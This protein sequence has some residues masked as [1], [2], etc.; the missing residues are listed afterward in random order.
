MFAAAGA[1]GTRPEPFRANHSDPGAEASQAPAD[2][3]A[4]GAAAGASAVRQTPSAFASIKAQLAQHRSREAAA[5]SA[6]GAGAADGAAA[7]GDASAAAASHA[8][9]PPA[10]PQAE[11]GRTAPE[12]LPMA[13]DA[14]DDV[15]TVMAQPPLAGRANEACYELC[16]FFTGAS[17]M[18]GSAVP[19][20]PPAPAP[21]TSVARSAAS[22]IAFPA[23]PGAAPAAGDAAAIAA[24]AGATALPD[25][26][27][28]GL[29]PAPGPLHPKGANAPA[30]PR[31]GQHFGCLLHARPILAAHCVTS[32]QLSPSGSHVLLAYGRR[33]I[34]LCSLVAATPGGALAAVHSV[35][36]VY[37]LPDLELRRVVLSTDD[38]V[39]VAV[40]NTFP[41]GGMAYGTKEGRLRLM[42][43]DR[44]RPQCSSISFAPSP[45]PLEPPCDGEDGADAMEP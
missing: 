32:V 23:A 25:S 39:N 41:G 44:R 30:P 7:A 5:A 3:N 17:P 19:A 40:F 14:A 26:G 34:S 16:I 33:H 18:P 1:T 42:R 8:V 29:P 24:D 13:T 22:S 4:G 20:P 28:S 15:A 38:E 43:Y 36:E 45:L 27:D 2:G 6:G 21:A 9:G 12:G 31:A 11:A 35:V 10:L 37:G